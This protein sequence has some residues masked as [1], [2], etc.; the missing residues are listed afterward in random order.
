MLLINARL[1]EQEGLWQLAVH[2]GVIASIT[3]QT[4]R[5]SPTTATGPADVLDAQGG[6]IIPPFVE[7]HIH[8]DTT[9]TAGQ[10][11]WNRSGTLFEGIER[12]AQRKAQLSIDD[13]KTRAWKTLRW[14]MANGVQHV[15][16]HVDVS[17]PTLTALKAMLEVRTEIAPWLDLQIVAFPQEGVLS[18]PNG[19][20]L[21]EE[22]LRLGADVVGAIPHFEFT[23]ELG[24]ESLHTIMELAMRY[25]RP[26]DVHCDETDDEQSRFLETLAYLAHR[27]GLGSRV[28][29][30]HTTAMH[31]YNGAYTSR[32][33]RLLSLSGINFVA[34]PLVNI[35]LQGRFDTYPKRRGMTRVPELLD[36]GLNVCF[37]HDD[38]FDPWYPL[39][40]GNMLQVLHMG[41]H[42]TQM[43]GYDQLNSSLNLITRNSA[44]TLGL[45]DYGIQTG[46]PANLLVLPAENGFDALRRQVRPSHSLRRG[47]LLAHTPPATTELYL[48]QPEPVNFR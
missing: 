16:T 29:A 48:H 7:P 41:M 45:K 18:Y 32:L 17:D 25:D 27:D 33:M 35:H 42:V 31:S 20:A 37:G 2:E 3:P 43:M 39:G 47:K 8:L 12:W 30:S 22:A 6:L 26:V 21:L 28:T 46:H 44:R 9:Q 34:N 5:D 15:R 38:V 19:P 10:P 14:Q 24:V 40:T 1:P 36:A 23:R 13:V 11:E 4:G